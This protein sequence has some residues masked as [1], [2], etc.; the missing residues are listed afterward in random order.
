MVGGQKQLPLKKGGGSKSVTVTRAD[1]SRQDQEPDEIDEKEQYLKRLK[2]SNS[3]S[4]GTK[5][6]DSGSSSS[7]SGFLIHSTTKKNQA[8]K[9]SPIPAKARKKAKHPTARKSTAPSTMLSS[10]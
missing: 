9:K 1:K 6:P 7:S 5:S 3:K 2:E 4:K 8:D 10:R